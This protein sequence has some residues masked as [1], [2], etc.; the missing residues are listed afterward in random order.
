M[1]ERRQSFTTLDGRRIPYT[2]D[3]HGNVTSITPPG[4]PAHTFIYTP[5]DLEETYNPP[6]VPN[7]GANQTRY[8]YNSTGK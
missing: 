3:V 5:V 1:P 2:Y 4:R 6:A 8:D 7:G